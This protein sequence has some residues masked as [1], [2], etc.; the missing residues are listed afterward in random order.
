M[1]LSKVHFARE[2]IFLCRLEDIAD[3]LRKALKLHVSF[4]WLRI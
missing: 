1:F 3:E 2:K 4:H